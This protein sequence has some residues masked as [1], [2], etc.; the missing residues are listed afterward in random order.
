M[1]VVYVSFDLWKLRLVVECDLIVMTILCALHLCTHGLYSS[2]TQKTLLRVLDS[3]S[4]TNPVM[5]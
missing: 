4:N 3:V 1:M 5:I 2:G